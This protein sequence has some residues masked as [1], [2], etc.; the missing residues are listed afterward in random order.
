MQNKFML[1]ERKEVFSC[2]SNSLKGKEKRKKESYSVL[3]S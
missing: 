2:S 1:D 3:C